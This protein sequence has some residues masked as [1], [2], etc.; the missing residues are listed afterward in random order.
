MRVTISLQQR[1]P[2]GPSA[3]VR[4][5]GSACRRRRHRRSLRSSCIGKVEHPFERSWCAPAASSW[6]RDR[7]RDRSSSLFLRLCFPEFVPA[8]AISTS[9]PSR[10]SSVNRAN[11]RFRDTLE[12][13]DNLH[14]SVGFDK[15]RR[16]HLY[17]RRA[18][19]EE[20]DSVDRSRDPPIPIIGSGH[21]CIRH[22]PW[23]AQ[24]V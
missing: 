1:P 21:C 11:F 16:P 24:P 9:S 10:S 18:A 8:H 7:A 20:L 14:R 2:F 3:L 19:Q 22:R 15:Q 4:T 6:D 5:R 17:S 12:I 23:P 13:G